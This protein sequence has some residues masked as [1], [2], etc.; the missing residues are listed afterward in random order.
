M[1]AGPVFPFRPIEIVGVATVEAGPSHGSGHNP[2][3][4]ENGITFIRAAE[5]RFQKWPHHSA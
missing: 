5:P 4:D 3:H 2:R 1:I